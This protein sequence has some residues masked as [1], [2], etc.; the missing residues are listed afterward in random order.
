MFVHLHN[1]SFRIYS[2]EYQDFVML[3]SFSHIV[4]LF[5][6]DR[7]FS[8]LH[9][10][11]HN[12]HTSCVALLLNANVMISLSVT[13]THSFL[14]SPHFLE[15]AFHLFLIFFKFMYGAYI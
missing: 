14:F 2:A 7:A 11:A 10:A 8:P 12:G 9:Y 3:L 6:F 1:N 15:G 13:F 4:L 5:S